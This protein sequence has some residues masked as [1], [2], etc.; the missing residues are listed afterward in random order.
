MNGEKKFIQKKYLH[1][2]LEDL[3]DIINGNSEVVHTENTTFPDIFHRKLPF[4]QLYAF[5]KYHKQYKYNKDLPHWSCVC[6][7]CENMVMLTKGLNAK[8]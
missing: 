6:E 4:R 2:K 8:I 3:L 5:L 7:K 1:W